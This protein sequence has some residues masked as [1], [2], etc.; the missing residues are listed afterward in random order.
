MAPSRVGSKSPRP[1]QPAKSAQPAAPSSVF[2]QRRPVARWAQAAPQANATQKTCKAGGSKDHYDVKGTEHTPETFHPKDG[3]ESLTPTNSVNMKSTRSCT[4][5]Y[6][7]QA[8]TGLTMVNDFPL[9]SLMC[10]IVKAHLNKRRIYGYVAGPANW[11]HFRC[12]LL[13]ANG[14]GPRKSLTNR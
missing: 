14:L 7:K 10:V 4:T 12:N 9:L 8:E 5:G 11:Y 2:A 3:Q 1:I 6:V 13:G